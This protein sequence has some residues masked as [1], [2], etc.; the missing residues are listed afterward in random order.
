MVC[1]E[2]IL[3]LTGSIAN[4]LKVELQSHLHYANLAMVLKKFLTW[5]DLDKSN[6]SI[7][8]WKK[9]NENRVR[10]RIGQKLVHSAQLGQDSM[11]AERGGRK[12][13]LT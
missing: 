9:K 5:L 4:L 10:L 12:L 6:D 11:N 8:Q 1:A 2:L 13:A 3:L 7:N